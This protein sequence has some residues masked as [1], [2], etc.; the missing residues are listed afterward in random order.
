M[1][2]SKNNA[3]RMWVEK[4]N[5][6]LGKPERHLA[7]IWENQRYFHSKDSDHE[8]DCFQAVFRTLP[9]FHSTSPPPTPLQAN[10]LEIMV[11]SAC[12][13]EQLPRF[14]E[15]VCLEKGIR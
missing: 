2:L 4:R 7:E 8:Y 15:I 12:Y 6:G 11:L 9:L 5:G 10:S 13:Q 1:M 3:F 14:Q